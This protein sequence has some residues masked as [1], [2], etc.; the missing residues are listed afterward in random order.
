LVQHND[1]YDSENQGSYSIK[2]YTSEK[3]IDNITGEWRHEQIILKPENSEY[4]NI[5][6]KNEEGFMVVGEF[7]G[8]V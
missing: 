4:E 8:L 6:I 2:K 5:L 1:V 7:I 3:V